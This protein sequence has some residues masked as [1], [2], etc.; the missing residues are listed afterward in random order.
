MAASMDVVDLARRALLEIII[1]IAAT[2]MAMAATASWFAIEQALSPLSAVTET[3]LQI[4]R[5]DDLS[6]RIP[7]PSSKHDE[8]AVLST[9]S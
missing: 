7:N 1:I 5:A 8:P 4:S 2:S 3:A 6:Q 9:L